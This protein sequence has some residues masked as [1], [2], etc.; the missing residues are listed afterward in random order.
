MKKRTII[1]I[2][3]LSIITMSILGGCSSVDRS[4]KNIQSDFGDG[5]LREVIVYDSVGNEIFRQKG[6][7]DIDYD[8]ERILY[9]DENNLRHVIYFK[10]GIVIVNELK[11]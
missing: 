8:D 3:I 10:N 5:L 2:S 1:I 4:L 9:D 6:K 7:F 11:E